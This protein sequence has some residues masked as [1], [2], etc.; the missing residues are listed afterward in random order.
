MITKRP[1]TMPSTYLSLNYHL[2]FSTQGREQW[3]SPEIRNRL[4]GYIGG[5]IKGLGGVGLQVGGWTDHVHLLVGLRG[6]HRLSEVVREV[7]KASTGFM[8]NEFQAS[9]FTWQEGY[10]GFTV[11]WRE[12][13]VVR[14]YIEQQEEHHSR[15]KLSFRDEL[16]QFLKENNVEYDPRYLD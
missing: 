13:D 2:V 14:R 8:R 7:K 1:A 9:H 12:L 10:A 6:E 15:G 16:I 3:I 4:Y 11:G 5:T